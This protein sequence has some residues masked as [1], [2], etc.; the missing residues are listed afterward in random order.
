MEAAVA[1]DFHVQAVDRYWLDVSSTD[2]LWSMSDTGWAK[3]AYGSFFSTWLAGACVFVDYAPKFDAERI[4]KVV[5]W[6]LLSAF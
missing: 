1:E 4:L 5:T 6:I 3:C 2:V